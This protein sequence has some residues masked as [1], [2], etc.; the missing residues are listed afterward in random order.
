MYITNQLANVYKLNNDKRRF[1]AVF[2]DGT[3]TKFG[4]SNQKQGT[5]IDH[6]DKK[7]RKKYINRHLR[8]LKTHDYTRAGYLSTFLL[9]NKPTLK[10]SIHD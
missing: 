4:Q 3:K 2:S 7:L 10:E 6:Q 5:Y 9:W 1:V 8:D